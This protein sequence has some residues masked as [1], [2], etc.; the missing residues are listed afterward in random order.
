MDGLWA[1]LAGTNR[2]EVIDDTG[3]AYEFW[4]KEGKVGVELHKQDNGRTL[5]IFISGERK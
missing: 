3:R 2:V 1:L 4:G 5:K